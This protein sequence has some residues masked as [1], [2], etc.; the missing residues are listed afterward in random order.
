MMEEWLEAIRALW[1]EYPAR[2][3]VDGQA[4]VAQTCARSRAVECAGHDDDPDLVGQSDRFLK[5][6]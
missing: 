5:R 3:C 2:I 1:P 4:T 6:S